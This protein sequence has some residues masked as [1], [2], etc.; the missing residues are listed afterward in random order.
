M[1][2]KKEYLKKDARREQILSAA[3]DIALTEGYDKLTRD[4]VAE[5][6]N[7]ATGQVNRIFSAMPKLK[8]AV[9]RATV[10]TLRVNPNDE[11]SL[12]IVAVGLSYREPIALSAPQHVKEAA[13]KLLM[14]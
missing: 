3:L 1:Q 5:R 10:E 14:G 12:L 4:G 2:A 11:R 13:L 7:V 8:A 9:M 6:A